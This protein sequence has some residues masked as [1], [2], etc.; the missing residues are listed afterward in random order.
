VLLS[1]GC[2]SAQT[3]GTEAERLAA[4]E[5]TIKLA[6]TTGPAAQRQPDRFDSLLRVLDQT[7]IVAEGVVTDVQNEYSPDTG[8]W[9]VVTLSQVTTHF[10]SAQS[11]L[12]I[13]QLGGPMPNGRVLS[14]SHQTAFLK[15]KKYLVFLRNTGWHLSPVVGGYAFRY[16]LVGGLDVLVDRDGSAVTGFDASGVLLSEPVFEGPRPDNAAPVALANAAQKVSGKALDGPTFVD[17][18]R[19]QLSLRGMKIS[20]SHSE[21]PMAGTNGMRAQLTAAPG[22]PSSTA[23]TSAPEPD[24]SGQ[25]P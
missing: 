11:Q 3:E 1:S 16:E 8:P 10:G 12:T 25:H 21:R 18:L 17:A 5:G 2:G 22:T 14:V 7:A 23:N 6:A 15:G 9:T 24:T 20:G 4:S 19:S 13:R